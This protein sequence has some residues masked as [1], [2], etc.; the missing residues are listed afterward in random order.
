[1]KNMYFYIFFF[2]FCIFIS[3]PEKAI[4]YDISSS[5]I[6]K[7][8]D[9]KKLYSK[10]KDT[11]KEEDFTNSAK[12]QLLNKITTKKENFN[13]ELNEPVQFGN[14]KITLLSCWK[15]PPN[16]NNESKALL[17]VYEKMSGEEDKKIFYN[18]MFASNPAFS[19]LQH[20]VYYV[21][22]MECLNNK[23][24]AAKK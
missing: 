3:A 18:W 5:L 7:E 23:N 12:I 21:K 14:L 8:E 15:S 24:L 2:V 10:Y 6:H 4:S 19:S 9:F 1:M 16:K 20:P 11:I 22:I 17:E 13:L